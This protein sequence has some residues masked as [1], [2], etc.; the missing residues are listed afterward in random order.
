MVVSNNEL[1]E[2]YRGTRVNKNKDIIFKQLYKNLEKGAMKICHYYSDYLLVPCRE[3]F[4]EEAL[5][6]SK[7]CLL[8]CI[9]S[10]C[11]NKNATF[12]TFYYKCLRNYIYNLFKHKFKSVIAEVT[13]EMVLDW[14]VNLNGFEDN[15]MDKVID[16]QDLRTI[17]LNNIDSIHFSKDKHKTIFVDYLGFSENGNIDENFNTLSRKYNLSRTAIKKICDK[18]FEI[19]VNN[20]ENTGDLDKIKIYL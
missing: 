9:D 1:V 12:S 7:L 2:L 14:A 18:Y 11:S 19:L 10:F 15:P 6:E 8:K 3:D 20:L 5:Q 16:N 4:F 17:F 13:D